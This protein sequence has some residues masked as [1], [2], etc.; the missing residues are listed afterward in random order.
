[1]EYKKNKLCISLWIIRFASGP[2]IWSNCNI[3]HINA[4]D[5]VGFNVTLRNG[6]KK[7]IKQ[8]TLAYNSECHIMSWRKSLMEYKTFPT[9]EKHWKENISHT[10]Y[11]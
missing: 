1:M 6:G 11:V 2:L 3:D 8:R 4:F 7:N 10:F 9:S 5:T